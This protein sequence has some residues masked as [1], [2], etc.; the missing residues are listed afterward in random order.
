MV[1]QAIWLLPTSPQPN[2][3]TC[4]QV[5]KACLGSWA[6][7]KWFSSATQPPVNITTGGRSCWTQYCLCQAWCRKY[8][9]LILYLMVKKERIKG[10]G[11]TVSL[12]PQN[13]ILSQTFWTSWTSVGI[14]K[15]TET[16]LSQLKSNLD[17]ALIQMWD[18][19]ISY[20]PNYLT[21]SVMEKRILQVFN[22]NKNLIQKTLHSVNRLIYSR[23]L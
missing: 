10:K 16:H 22:G 14:L 11:Q 18:S 21:I 2:P 4:S 20:S 6:L 12:S 9:L 17:T 23:I 7:H 15:V 13:W 3:W 8:G 19:N 5:R 1:I